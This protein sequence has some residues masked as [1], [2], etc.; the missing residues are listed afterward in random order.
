MIDCWGA[1]DAFGARFARLPEW[2]EVNY[3]LLICG[4]G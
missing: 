3:L 1:T 2:P 4:T